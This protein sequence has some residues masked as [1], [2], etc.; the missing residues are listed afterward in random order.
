VCS[1]TSVAKMTREETIGRVCVCGACEI[2]ALIRDKHCEND[3]TKDRS[4]CVVERPAWVERQQIGKDETDYG[5]CEMVGLGLGG[6]ETGEEERGRI[7]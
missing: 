3:R 5:G 2:Q 4:V 7:E 6:K 1:E